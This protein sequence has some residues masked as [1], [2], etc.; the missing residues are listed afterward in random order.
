MSSES[1]SDGDAGRGWSERGLGMLGMV[2]RGSRSYI[3]Y[4]PQSWDGTILK[5]VT[6]ATSQGG[7]PHTM[8]DIFVAQHFNPVSHLIVS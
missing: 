1:L 7:M 4:I 5:S 8:I 3:S 2:G 6:S